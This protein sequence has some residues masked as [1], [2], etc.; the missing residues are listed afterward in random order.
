MYITI[1]MMQ[2]KGST[3]PEVVGCVDDTQM[4]SD[5]K[6][7]GNYIR[8]RRIVL[9]SVVES[10]REITVY[11]PTDEIRKVFQPVMLGH[12]PITEWRRLNDTMLFPPV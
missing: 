3:M 1:L 11:V 7:W 8:D 12:A 6:Y 9:A 4:E 5:P 2:R 10:W